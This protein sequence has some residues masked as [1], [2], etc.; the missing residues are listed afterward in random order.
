MKIINAAFKDDQD[1][2]I[3]VAMFVLTLFFALIPALIV[4]FIPKNYISEATYE[5]AKTLFNFEL[6]L[7]LVSL[8][9]LIPIIGWIASAIIIPVILIWN[10]IIVVINLCS[11]AK[12]N[13]AKLPEY[14]KFI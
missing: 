6:L 8:L 2:L 7:F 14:Y 12:D 5:I 10:A 11:I 3:T 9:C 1:R 13:V 4:V